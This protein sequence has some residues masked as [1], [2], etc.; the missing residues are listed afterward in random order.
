MIKITILHAGINHP[1][2]YIYS[3]CKELDKYDDIEYIITPELPLKEKA[4]RCSIIY[5]HRLKR[6]Y[7]CNSKRSGEEFIKNVKKLKANGHFIAWTIHNFLPIDRPTTD[8]DE[9]VLSEF[10]KNADIVFTLTD[11]MRK[12]LIKNFGRKSITHYIGINKL[13]GWFD[14][15]IIDLSSL[16]D[17]AFLFTF[18][19][20]IAPYKNINQII[21]NFKMI[22]NDNTYLLIAGPMAKNVDISL[23]LSSNIIRFDKFIG[24]KSWKKI[25]EKTNVFINL[26][27]L[28]YPN[29]KYGFFPSNS[30]TLSQK[31]IKVITPKCEIID[32]LLSQNMMIN[33]DFYDN[34]D[35]LN[36][37][38]WAVNNPQKLK[39][40]EKKEYSWYNTV[41]IIVNEFR[42]IERGNENVRKN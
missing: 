34:N 31:G 28:D 25:C 11:Y 36:K 17:D 2:P 10:L 20:N 9:Y 4:D 39:F 5:F 32:E 14:K 24:E 22:N 33:F 8:V 35:L 26:Y 40:S 30:V 37:M 13:D 38:K 19:G 16:S 15:E 6:Y 7:D 42:K 23:N 29:F 27:D 41:R 3:M 18:V 21:E 1:S 12:S